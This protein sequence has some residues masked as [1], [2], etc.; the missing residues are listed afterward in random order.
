[1]VQWVKNLQ[2]LG[3]LWR[4]GLKDPML[5]KLIPGPGSSVAGVA[6]KKQTNKHAVRYHSDPRG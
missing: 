3:S 5:S 1:M 2:Q 6:I 4:R